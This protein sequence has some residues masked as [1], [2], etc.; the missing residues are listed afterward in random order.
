MRQNANRSINKQEKQHE[1][2]ESSHGRHGF[3]VVLTVNSRIRPS[4]GNSRIDINSVILWD[5]NGQNF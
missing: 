1:R 5:E 4:P 3:H 2:Q